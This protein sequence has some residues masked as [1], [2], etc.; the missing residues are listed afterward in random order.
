[1][2]RHAAD[3]HIDSTPGQGTRFVVTFPVSRTSE[4][5]GQGDAATPS[6]V[7]PLRI[8]VIDDDPLVLPVL[9][10]TL[11][12]DGHTV[13]TADEPRRGIELFRAA[14]A[15]DA[16]SVVIT[17]LGMPHLDGRAVA[18]AIKQASPTTPI[19]LL[20]GWGKRLDAEGSPPQGINHILAK[21]PKLRE[22]RAAL[23]QCL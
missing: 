15:T 2:R 22:L 18:R 9:K 6:S 14:Q 1:V 16:F 13:V 19:I 5:A 7:T 10:A 21:P 4:V 17:D 20:T 23:A 3:I 11:E 8:L 12:I